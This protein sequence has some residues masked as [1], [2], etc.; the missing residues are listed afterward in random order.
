MSIWTG[1]RSHASVVASAHAS[2]IAAGNASRAA[3]ARLVALLAS[4]REDRTRAAGARD[5]GVRGAR[6]VA[7]G[8]AAAVG[9]AGAAASAGGSSGGSEGGSSDA[10]PFIPEQRR[11]QDR[12]SVFTTS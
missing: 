9:S 6:G 8:R 11:P 7:S 5:G 12:A 1:V 4:V 10:E 3:A 2:R